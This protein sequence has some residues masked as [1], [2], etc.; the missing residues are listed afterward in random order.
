MRCPVSASVKILMNVRCCLESVHGHNLCCSW[1]YQSQADYVHIKLSAII[2]SCILELDGKLLGQQKIINYSE[3][4][5]DYSFIPLT[6][7]RS[8]FVYQGKLSHDVDG[9]FGS[10]VESDYGLRQSFDQFKC[11][12][13]T[14]RSGKLCVKCLNCRKWSK[15]ALVARLHMSRED[16]Q[17]TKLN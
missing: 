11:I 8:H 7:R 15:S 13:P 16:D 17:E 9:L 14:Y 10:R 4:I 6:N 3:H 12:N 1:C 5:S 2:S